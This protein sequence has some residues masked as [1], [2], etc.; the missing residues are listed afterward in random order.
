MRRRR[1]MRLR[2]PPA[3]ASRTT[4]AIAVLFVAT[5]ALPAVA[6]GAPIRVHY[7]EGPTRGFLAVS[8]MSGSVIAHGDVMQRVEGRV[9]ASRLLLRFDD[10]SLYDQTVRFT[11]KPV[12]RVVAYHLIQRGPS[13]SE[14]TDV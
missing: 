12:F 11:Q 10:G 3:G 4:A 5:A 14:A 13:F 1:S 6:T 7:P 2:K 8:D 9:V